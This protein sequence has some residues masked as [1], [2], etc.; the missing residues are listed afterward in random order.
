MISPFPRRRNM[1]HM[2]TC[3]ASFVFLVSVVLLAFVVY[4]R[5]WYGAQ[6]ALDIAGARIDGAA[7]AGHGEERKSSH[8][9]SSDQAAGHMRD[10]Y[11]VMFDAGSTGTRVHIFKFTQTN[12]AKLP[13]LA[14]EVFH[15][16]KPGL[17]AYADHPEESVASVDSLLEVA[18]SSVPENHWRKTP[19]VLKATAGLRL[20][21]ESKSD[22]LLQQMKKL[23]DYC[24]FNL[25][26]DG[27]A[28]MDG[29]DEGI[30]SWMT[31][32]FLKGTL[33][34]VQNQMMGILDLGG[35]STQITFIPHKEK[36]LQEVHESYSTSF[37]MFNSTYKLYSHSY[38]GLGLMS[39]RLAVLGGVESLAVENGRRLLSPCLPSQYKS[40]WVHAGI[41]YKIGGVKGASF[42]LCSQRVEK[43]IEGKVDHPNEL[44]EH[45]FYAFS[46]YFD[47]AVDV[48]LITDE[49][50][51]TLLVQHYE[52]KAKEVCDGMEFGNLA[53]QPFLCIDLTYISALLQRGFGFPKYMELVLAK[54]VKDV[55][56]SW[57][58]GA[59][60]QSI[61]M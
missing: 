31:I 47:R 33:R 60:F 40:K 13:Q 44:K 55:E 4:V 57:A 36:T 50:G 21:P 39:A 14:W 22:A 61:Q 59:A 12:A 43:I 27:I 25:P 56:T 11:S 16:V 32:N 1:K 38:L 48:G 23:F 10:Y 17:S 49:N 5:F 45:V 30:F 7:Q 34:S 3:P 2:R 8:R 26:E 29:I 41:A 35:G 20:L 42:K 52:D 9:V 28:I 51:G 58:L 54:K 53:S 15:S 18:K 19:V 37:K 6:D 24:P 46:Y